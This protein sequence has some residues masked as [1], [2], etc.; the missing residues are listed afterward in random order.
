MPSRIEAFLAKWRGSS[1]AE[2]ANKDMFLLDFCDALEL[3]RPE[4]KRA[5]SPYC[6]EKEIPD[7]TLA[8]GFTKTFVDLYKRDHFLLEAKQTTERQRRGTGGTHRRGPTVHAPSLPGMVEEPETPYRAPASYDA[9]MEQAFGQVVGYAK[10]LAL[11]GER[12][13]FLIVCDIGHSF[14]VWNRFDPRAGGGYGGFGAG[15]VILLDELEDPETQAYFRKIWTNP[16]ELDTSRRRAVVTREIARELGKLA[17]ELAGENDRAHVTRFLMRCVFTCFAEDIGLFKGKPFQEGLAEFESNSDG[18]QEFLEDWWRTMDTGGKWGWKKVLRFN[19]SLFKDVSV[20][21]LSQR[22]LSLLHLA[23]KENWSEIEPAIFGTLLESALDERERHALGAHYT[24]RAYI[25]RLVDAT[26]GN[27]LRR[28]WE[29]VEAD[30]AGLLK[31]GA[32]EAASNA[33]KAKLHAFQDRLASLTVLDPACGSGNFLY[34]AFDTI[35][36]LEEEV[37]QR[38]EELGEHHSIFSI[39]HEKVSPKQFKGLEVNGWAAQIAE[40]VLWIA[41][42][43]WYRRRHP[44][45][46]PPEPVLQNYGS[47]RE[48]DAVLAWTGTEPTGRSRHG[49]RRRMNPVTGVDE[50]DPSDQVPILAYMNPSVPAWPDVDYIVGNP[51][52]L[53]NSQMRDGLGDGYVEA[54]RAAYPDV[55]DTVDFVLY[56]WHRAAEQVR[57]GKAKAFG[58]ITT[59]SLRQV[60]N[61]GVLAHETAMGLRL[62]FAIPD[63]PWAKDQQGAAVRISMTVGGLEGES[64]LWRVV[65]ETDSAMPEEEAEAVLLEGGVVNEIHPDLSAGAAVVE[66][67]PLSAN[68]GL[69]TRGVMLFGK[70]FIVE[71]DQW[72]AWGRPSIVH[73]YRNG[74]DLTDSPRNVMV[75]DAFALEES[76]L[77]KEFPAVYQHLLRTVKPERDQNNR[78]L[79]KKFWWLFGEPNPGLHAML[80]G[81]HRYIATVET[82]K[83]R[84]FQFLDGAIVPDNKIVVIASYDALHLGVL[85]SRIHV[86]WALATGATLEDRP[87]YPKSTCFDPF[88]FPDPTPAQARAIRDLAEEL[89]AHRKA[90]QAKGVS[91]TKQYNLLDKL[92]AEEPF[93]QAEQVLDAKALPSV[94]KELHDRLD[95]AVA[96]AYGW[97]AD[98][99]EAAILERLMAL[100]AERRAEEAAGKVRWLRP[101]Y[102]APAKS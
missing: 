59:N 95:R 45:G 34:V 67:G 22:Q 84:V 56:W 29:A 43:Q 10:A 3:E 16:G 92:R 1:G 18:A 80:L 32:T 102:Q 37:L 58:L 66:A 44:M 98:L 97:P 15:R 5:D 89:D 21:R 7:I 87:V 39:E 11:R 88:P 51:P 72:Q 71:P 27:D 9:L 52:F 31:E 40:L 25:Q 2:R 81:L 8:G 26:F 19:G 94:L 50:P 96:E 36:H 100:N 93:T 101:E 83:H 53:G 99:S 76:D 75:I 41:Y 38:L 62:R 55:P 12:P 6:F 91:L 86:S 85:S 79:R 35:K 30:V 17:I 82:A 4:P 77:R 69:C 63:H 14:R 20:P 70:G 74:R 60:R 46:D 23:A 90:A 57:A 78:E 28:A 48:G 49:G 47:I 61:R 64:E 73:P 54:L 33:A 68:A 42:L 65:R 24:P 13:P